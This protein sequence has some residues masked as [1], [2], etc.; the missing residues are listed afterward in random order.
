MVPSSYS[1]TYIHKDLI[2]FPQLPLSHSLPTPILSQN[3]I[4]VNTESKL[5]PQKMHPRASR[6]ITLLRM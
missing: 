3:H 2:Y 4:N 1:S 5:L 6:L